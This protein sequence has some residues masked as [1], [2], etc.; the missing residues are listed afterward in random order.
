M[1]AK[2]LSIEKKFRASPVLLASLADFTYAEG[3][4]LQPQVVI[5]Q[6]NLSLYCLDEQTR[7]MIFVET[8][9]EVDLS[10]APFYYQA[11]FEHAYRLIALP[12]E[13]LHD[14]AKKHPPQDEALILIYSVGRCGSTLL[15]QI[16]NL[17]DQVLS[18]S[19]PDI[20]T[21]IVLLREPDGSRDQELAELL[22]SCVAVL[23][24]AS[25]QKRPSVWAFKFRAFCIQIADLLYRNHPKAK[26]LFL[27]R[28]AE[29]WAHSSVRAFLA[30]G[31]AN[32][33]MM[34]GFWEVMTRFVPLLPVYMTKT[35]T[36][37]SATEVLTLIWLSIMQRYLSLY[38]QG[39][40]ICATR[41]ED[42]V[43]AP[44]AV[45]QALFHYCD[46]PLPEP[47]RLAQV[48]AKDSQAGSVLSRARVQQPKAGLDETELARLRAFLQAEPVINTPDFVMPGT[49]KFS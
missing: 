4:S 23:C 3:E 11:Q 37:L 39:L 2:V 1:S 29:S 41:Y 36:G 42:L 38:K 15:S 30:S 10:A 32:E 35:S 28:E 12:Y 45:I 18:L 31:Q 16:F 24:K 14:L 47:A 43:T 8:P 22:A 33:H 44:E 20:F 26:S 21:Q 40:P 13:A 34:Q 25:P 6:P 5:D 48:L 46:L 27:Y 19:E 49:L 9:P 17:P 7:Q